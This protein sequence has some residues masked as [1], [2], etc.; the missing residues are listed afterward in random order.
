MYDTLA[1]RLSGMLTD[2]LMSAIGIESDEQKLKQTYS[3]IF[4]DGA[5]KIKVEVDALATAINREQTRIF[6]N[7]PITGAS[8]AGT[9][10]PTTDEKAN[11][12]NQK[13]SGSIV[14]Q[15]MDGDSNLNKTFDKSNP[16]S[17]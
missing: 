2:S 6:G 11:T 1:K 9:G 14:D 4:T 15:L 7:D 5:A 3:D 8:K 16:I 10:I 12:I 13:G 17:K